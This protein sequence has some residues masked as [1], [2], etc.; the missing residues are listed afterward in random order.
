[1]HKPVAAKDECVKKIG[2]RGSEVIKEEKPEILWRTW[3][4]HHFDF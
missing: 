2:A 3:V 1:M 4:T